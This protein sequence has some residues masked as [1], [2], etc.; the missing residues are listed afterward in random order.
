MYAELYLVGTAA[1]AVTSAQYLRI[2]L[3]TCSMRLK[4][5]RQLEKKLPPDI[6]AG[7]HRVR[8]GASEPIVVGSLKHLES[9][10]AKDKCEDLDKASSHLTTLVNQLNDR[11]A[12]EQN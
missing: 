5:A 6:F 2:T 9:Q 8:R 1:P 4:T 12:R 11:G 10:L 3:S 7:A